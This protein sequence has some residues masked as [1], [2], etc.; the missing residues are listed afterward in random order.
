MIKI[1]KEV[2]TAICKLIN[3][4]KNADIISTSEYLSGDH[5]S[6]NWFLEVSTIAAT[7]T[8]TS[9]NIKHYA[10]IVKQHSIDRKLAKVAQEIL[11]GVQ[12]K[13]ENRLDRAQQRI[14][15][16]AES[17]YFEILN[18]NDILTTVMQRIDIRA[19][20]PTEVTGIST[21]FTNLDKITHGLQP[22]HLIILAAR[23]SMGKTLLAMNIAEHVALNQKKL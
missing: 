8:F 2:Y 14:A 15:E 9:K 6:D 3:S 7:G 5:K 18:V 11:S 4:G 23:P 20:N 17:S 16:L 1:N 13:S 12:N 10:E 19:N 22:G 21:G